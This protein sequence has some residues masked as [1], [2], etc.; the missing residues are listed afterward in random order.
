[1]V[2]FKVYVGQKMFVPFNI[3]AIA[4]R[5]IYNDMLKMTMEQLDMEKVIAEVPFYADIKGS[6]MFEMFIYEI[7]EFL[8]YN[9][10]VGGSRSDMSAHAGKNAW[11]QIDKAVK[12]QYEFIQSV[13]YT[14]WEDLYDSSH[15]KQ[16]FKEKMIERENA[17]IT[18]FPQHQQ[19][20]R[21]YF[22]QLINNFDENYA[23]I[24][25]SYLSKQYGLRF[26]AEICTFL[27][28]KEYVKVSDLPSGFLDNI[29]GLK[30]QT[31]NGQEC[32]DGCYAFGFE[33]HDSK[34]YTLKLFRV[35]DFSMGKQIITTTDQYIGYPFKTPSMFDIISDYY[36]LPVFLTDINSKLLYSQI[37]LRDH[38]FINCGS[39]W[40]NDVEVQE[41]NYLI[42]KDGIKYGINAVNFLIT[43]FGNTHR[44]TRLNAK[45]VSY[46]LSYNV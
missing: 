23:F 24:P 28:T 40:W 11:E 25:S 3:G 34:D 6:E 12:L 16:N 13:N 15:E 7:L 4:L 8:V 2:K 5:N 9:G 20:L 43:R 18:S 22:K 19:P 21:N 14:I 37:A 46:E 36:F 41:E 1:M 38:K 10:H 33:L 30:L 35:S 32:L 27:P 44:I 17:L 26:D 39:M 42:R 29:E 31:I 45:Y